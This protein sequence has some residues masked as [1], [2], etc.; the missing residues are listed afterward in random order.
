MRYFGV[1]FKDD[2]GAVRIAFVGVQKPRGNGSNE[3]VA[4]V[5]FP[6]GVIAPSSL[7]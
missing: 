6:A 5:L 7:G 2:V 4:P 1:I 3:I